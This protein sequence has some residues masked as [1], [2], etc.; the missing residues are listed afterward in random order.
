M[1]LMHQWGG[2]CESLIS[3]SDC[4]SQVPSRA[5][6]LEVNAANVFQRLKAADKVR[7]ITSHHSAVLCCLVYLSLF[8]GF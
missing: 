8:W 4:Q 2:W 7:H 1:I 3:L 5:S 6:S